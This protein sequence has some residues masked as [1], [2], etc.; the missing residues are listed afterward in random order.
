MQKLQETE[1]RLVSKSAIRPRASVKS[2]AP[3]KQPGI[4]PRAGAGAG[5]GAK[6]PDPAE[7]AGPKSSAQ[8][9]DPSK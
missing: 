5:P 1:K 8:A 4:S 2:T 9:Q 7:A 6:K 3:G